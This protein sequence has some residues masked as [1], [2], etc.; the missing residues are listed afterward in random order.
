MKDLFGIETEKIYLKWSRNLDDDPVKLGRSIPDGILS[1]KSIRRDLTFGKGTWRLSSLETKDAATSS[2]V[3]PQ[4]FE[5]TDYTVFIKSKTPEPISLETQNPALIRNLKIFDEGRLIIGTINFGSQVGRSEF[6]T[7]TGDEPEFKF[8]VEVYPSK[9]DPRDYNQILDEVQDIMTGL[10]LEYLKSTFSLGSSKNVP[11]PTHL[12]WLI[13][14]RKQIEDLDRALNQISLHP[15]WG[16]IRKSQDTRIERIK[17]PDSHIR[18]MIQ[19]GMGKGKHIDLGNNIAI[20]ERLTERRVR[21]TLDTPEHRWLAS[22]LVRIRRRLAWLY[23]EEA[24]RE[25]GDRRDLTLREINMMELCLSRF[26]QLAPI[27]EANGDPPI[28]FASVQLLYAPGYK[29]AYRACLILS[30]GLHI[31]NGP[32]SLPLKDLSLLYEYWCFFALLRLAA[33]ETGQK[34]PF[35]EMIAVEQNS[36]RIH[37]QKGREQTI[38]FCLSDGR[39][40]DIIYNPLF[41]GENYLVPQQPDIVLKLSDPKQQMSQFILDAKYRIDLSPEYIE[42]YGSAGPPEEALNVLYR[43]RDAIVDIDPDKGANLAPKR[44]VAHAIAL[45]PYKETIPNSFRE[46]R[47]WLA[48]EKLGVGAIPILPDNTHH[49][50][51]WLHMILTRYGKDQIRSDIPAADPTS[52]SE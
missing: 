36:L 40:L 38:H 17:R 28:G 16:L 48:I 49:L 37:L 27:K 30:L 8:E 33:E 44:T 23:L 5:Q 13:L 32:L 3:G 41:R 25:S 52:D 24:K 51:E 43:Y 29:E 34:I 42:Q 2:S 50:S 9:L 6:L 46:C 12:E 18:R 22:Q 15:K 26:S 21:L 4:L 14:L 35:K 7:R 47:L 1:I 11:K 19:K 45:F 10:I 20:H 31:E 39:K